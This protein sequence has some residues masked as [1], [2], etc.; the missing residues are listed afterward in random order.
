MITD[1]GMIEFWKDYLFII[2]ASGS[3]IGGRLCNDSDPESLRNKDN[4][5]LRLANEKE[6]SVEGVDLDSLARKII[7]AEGTDGYYVFSN[8]V[9][10]VNPDNNKLGA[11][12]L[13]DNIKGLMWKAMHEAGF[14]VSPDWNG[15]QGKFNF[16]RYLQRMRSYADDQLII[17]DKDATH[18]LQLTNKEQEA[19]EDYRIFC[20]KILLTFLI[21]YANNGKVKDES[22]SRVISHIVNITDE[23]SSGC[24][25]VFDLTKVE[26]IE[27]FWKDLF[28]LTDY[29]TYTYIFTNIGQVQNEYLQEM[30]ISMMKSEEYCPSCLIHETLVDFSQLNI[31]LI[32]RVESYDDTIPAYVPGKSFQVYIKNI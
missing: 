10:A 18:H 9:L 15:R 3:I 4:I 24:Y 21:G 20:R 16:I 29:S 22:L 13:C 23:H 2:T 17:L 19:V 6:I 28:A 32:N 5:I 25:R 31:I 8:Y 1:L 14:I 27:Q 30:V 26:D 12:S 11:Y 7:K